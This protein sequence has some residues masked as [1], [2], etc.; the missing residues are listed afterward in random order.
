[1]KVLELFSG[2]HSIGVICKEKGFDVLSLD[3]DL[4]E[5]SKLYDYV[6]T[7]HIQDDIMTWNYKQF[8]PEHFD[9]ITMSPVC[10]WWSQMRRCRVSVEKIE[11]DINNLG[12]PMVDRCIEI[13][14][15]LKPKYYWIENPETGVMKKYMKDKYPHIHSKNYI[16]DYCQYDDNIKYQKRTIFWTNIPNFKPKLC[17]GEGNCPNMDGKRHKVNIASNQYVIVDSKRIFINTKSLREKYKDYEKHKQLS[18]KSKYDR[19]K[20]PL[21]LIRELFSCLNVDN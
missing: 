14:N 9:L 13:L 5:F 21:N 7:N 19:Y 20:I 8:K 3:R 15:Y 11:E 4:N 16:V 18:T 6:S 2:T 10:Q 1:M 17:S 12:K